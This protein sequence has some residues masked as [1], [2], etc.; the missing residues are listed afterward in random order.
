[1]VKQKTPNK[2]GILKIVSGY[3]IIWI[4]PYLPIPSH[5]GYLDFLIKTIGNMN[6]IG[7]L[8]GTPTRASIGESP[9]VG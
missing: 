9:G 4:I 8:A 3:W 1:L 2:Y 7:S 5:F 6:L